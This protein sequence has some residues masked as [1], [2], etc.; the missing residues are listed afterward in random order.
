MKKKISYLISL[1]AFVF[2]MMSRKLKVNI[3]FNFKLRMLKII[4][5]KIKEFFVLKIIMSLIL[6]H[7]MR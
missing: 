5:F 3:I 7:M 1:D 2:V 4:S 6:N